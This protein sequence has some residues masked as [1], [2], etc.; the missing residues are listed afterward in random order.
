M[1]MLERQ[2]DALHL[3]GVPLDRVFAGLRRLEPSAHAAYVYDLGLVAARAQLL[4]DAFAAFPVLAA[5]AV[6][7]NGLPALLERIARE[8]LAAD[9]GSLGELAL[10]ESA[11][12]GYASTPITSASSTCSS[13]RRRVPAT[14]CAWRCG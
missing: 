11:G 3:G 12:F 7:A 2:G 5:Y 14:R 4:K 9:T 8:G 10:A 1:T 13:V 6:K